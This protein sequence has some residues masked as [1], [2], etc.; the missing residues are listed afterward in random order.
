MARRRVS[1]WNEL[2]HKG[3]VYLYIY[4]NMRDDSDMPEESGYNLG[5]D[6]A[7]F[8]V[9]IYDEKENLLKEVEWEADAILEITENDVI[10]I[11]K[12]YKL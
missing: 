3:K 8:N 1:E 12:K 2:E 11:I 4:E 9:E 5:D 6:E 10:D 7:F